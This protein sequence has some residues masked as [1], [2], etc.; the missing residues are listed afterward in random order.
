VTVLTGSRS[1]IRRRGAAVVLTLGV[2]LLSACGSD[3]TS[4]N[5]ADATSSS[6]AGTTGDTGQTLPTQT[7]EA[8]PNAGASGETQALAVNEKEFAIEMPSTDLTAGSY[9]IAVTNSGNFPHDLKI[10]QHGD[11]IAGTEQLAAGASGNLS[12][13]LEPGTYIFYCGVG[14]HRAMGM[15]VTVTVT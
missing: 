4:G 7:S 15:E 13:T 9:E 1:R 12:V 5:S 8:D 2:G 3:G 6:A 14:N 10:E 11:T